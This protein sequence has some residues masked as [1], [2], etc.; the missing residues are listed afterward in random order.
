MKKVR[1]QVIALKGDLQAA[2]GVS[3]RLC[4]LTVKGLAMNQTHVES[5][6]AHAFRES[7]KGSPELLDTI[8]ELFTVRKGEVSDRERVNHFE[9]VVAR[10]EKAQS[11]SK[12]NAMDHNGNHVNK[13]DVRDIAMHVCNE[14][15]NQNALSKPV[16]NF[17][18][19]LSASNAL[20]CSTEDWTLKIWAPEFSS[21]EARTP[22]G[23]DPVIT[24]MFSLHQKSPSLSTAARPDGLGLTELVH[25]TANNSLTEEL[26]NV[27]RFAQG[28]VVHALF[29]NDYE[30]ARSEV[31]AN[32]LFKQTSMV[33]TN[34]NLDT[35]SLDAAGL[36]M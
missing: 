17:L 31:I 6:V 2:L 21:Y 14:L 4:E 11:V 36:S 3:R 29:Q 33:I 30:G 9:S 22:R 16:L 28:K 25:Q 7:S 26:K 8:H 1:E 24:G 20:G 18:N 19:K 13:N 35:S 34:P 32:L 15:N 5:V 27:D 23:M 10:H 12:S